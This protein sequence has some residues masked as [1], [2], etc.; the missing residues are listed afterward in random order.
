MTP[1]WLFCSWLPCSFHALQHFP[2]KLLPHTENPK[3]TFPKIILAELRSKFFKGFLV[4]HIRKC[5]GLCRFVPSNV[6]YLWKQPDFSFNVLAG[7]DKGK[8]SF[9]IH[10][11]F[12]D[13]FIFFHAGILAIWSFFGFQGLWGKYLW[14]GSSRYEMCIYPV[15]VTHLVFLYMF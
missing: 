13:C 3:S 2:E 5:V 12:S 14:T 15:S 9:L 6:A 11:H 4:S 7:C 1:S 8:A 10:S